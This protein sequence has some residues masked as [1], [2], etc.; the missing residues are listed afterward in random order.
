MD[1]RLFENVSEAVSPRLRVDVCLV[2]QARLLVAA[3]ER[4]VRRLRSAEVAAFG[5]VGRNLVAAV[6]EVHKP[7]LKLSARVPELVA[8]TRAGVRPVLQLAEQQVRVHLLQQQVV[9]IVRHC[10]MEGSVER[11]DGFGRHVPDAT[12]D[13]RVEALLHDGADVPLRKLE[14][15]VRKVGLVQH[16]RNVCEFLCEGAERSADGGLVELGR[17]WR[18]AIRRWW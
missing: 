6:G 16:I 14:G 7:P 5:T 1:V 3:P 18:W 17:R 4:V 2:Q 10:E 8:V 9:S 13:G 12:H 11:S 15:S